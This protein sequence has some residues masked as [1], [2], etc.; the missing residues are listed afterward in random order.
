MYLNHRYHDDAITQEVVDQ[1]AENLA[2]AKVERD[3]F[4]KKANRA[5]KHADALRNVVQ[6]IERDL[7]W[8]RASLSSNV[9]EYID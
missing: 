4:V 5:Q 6:L 1:L 7:R 9:D 3:A 2:T 8:C